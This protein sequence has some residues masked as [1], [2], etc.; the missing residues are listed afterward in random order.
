MFLSK[1]EQNLLNAADDIIKYLELNMKNE[2]PLE[3]ILLLSKYRQYQLDLELE[4][5]EDLENILNEHNNIVANINKKQY[6]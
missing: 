2:L 1:T 3:L 5:G 6:N 4:I